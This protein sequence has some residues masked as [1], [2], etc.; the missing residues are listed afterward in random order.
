MVIEDEQVWKFFDEMIKTSNA[1]FEK[2]KLCFL[3]NT[4]NDPTSKNFISVVEIKRRKI[5]EYINGL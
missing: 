2:F 1:E 3:E 4:G 5:A